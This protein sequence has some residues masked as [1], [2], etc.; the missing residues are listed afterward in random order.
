MILLSRE[1]IDVIH[2]NIIQLHG[3][4]PG[5]R[6]EWMLKSALN[7][8]ISNLQYAETDVSALTA[9]Y[10]FGIIQG[11]PFLDGNKRTA[12]LAAVVFLQLNELTASISQ[13][14]AVVLVLSVATGEIDET[15]AAMFFGDY[16]R[17]LAA[18]N[19]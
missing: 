13:E 7:R 14:E 8:P 17:S 19:E 12:L 11:R 9:A 4:A 18:G 16:C 5:L 6:D 3:G 10:L 15:G 2:A 1:I